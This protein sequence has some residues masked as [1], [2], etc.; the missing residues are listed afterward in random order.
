[1]IDS[2]TATGEAGGGRRGRLQL[3]HEREPDRSERAR[4]GKAARGRGVILKVPTN[5]LQHVLRD[6]YG[7]SCY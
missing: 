7:H 6:I 5:L 2:P 3:E 4:A 1:M